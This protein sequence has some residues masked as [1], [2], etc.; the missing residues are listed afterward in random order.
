MLGYWCKKHRNAINKNKL[1][2]S[3]SKS[4]YLIYIHFP[5]QKTFYSD[6]K[7]QNIKINIKYNIIQIGKIICPVENIKITEV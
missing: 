7:I 3:R 6:K 2:S 1:F 5:F 4:E